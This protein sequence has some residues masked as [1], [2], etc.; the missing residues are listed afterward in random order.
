M[1]HHIILDLDNCIADDAWRIPKI[2]WQKSDPMDRYHDYHSLSAFD[3]LRNEDILV[4]VREGT[5]AAIIFTARPVQY[6]AIT[7]EWLRRKEVPFRY[8]IMR[9]NNDRRPSLE[10]KRTMLH[11]LPEVYDVPWNSVVAAYDDRPDI[12]AMYRKNHMP[13]FQRAVHDVCAYTAPKEQV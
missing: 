11:W 2:N 10:L 3:D 5:E 6:R 9:N 8:L 12:V 13:G 1:T 4:G 7:E